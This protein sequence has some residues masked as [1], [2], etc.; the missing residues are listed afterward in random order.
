MTPEKDALIE[1]K[2]QIDNNLVNKN[3]EEI[4]KI[5]KDWKIE[6]FTKDEV[7]L[8]KEEND[9]CNEHYLLKNEN[10]YV[11]VYKIGEHNEEVLIEDT[12]IAVKYLEK[13]D[14]DALNKGVAIYTRE[15][16]NKSLEDFGHK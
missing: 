15:E 9:I 6:K 5:Y 3:K 8:F 1:K 14:V 2:M 7:V 13:E 12:N 11:K 4:E 10:E 16:L